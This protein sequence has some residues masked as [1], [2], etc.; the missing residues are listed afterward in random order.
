MSELNPKKVGISV[1]CRTCGQ[2]KK[3]FGR[4][5]PLGLYLC[6]FECPGYSEHPEPGHL[7]PGESEAD[8]GY[9]VPDVSV[10]ITRKP[11]E[12]PR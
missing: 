7:W 2:R 10:R 11:A 5:A 4:S 12:D 8:F 6:T 1:S 9:P 3:P